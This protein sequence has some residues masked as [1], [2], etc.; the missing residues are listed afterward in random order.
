MKQ[1]KKLLWYSLALMGF[2]TV[3]GFGNVVNGFSFYGGTRAVGAWVLIFAL[4]FVP[5]ALMVGELGSAFKELGGGV[6]SWIEETVGP[7]LAYYAGWTYWVVHM[8]YISQKPQSTIIA[9]SWALFQDNRV[10]LMNPLVLQLLC[11]AV[12]IFAFYLSGKGLGILKKLSSVAGS[13]MFVMS[14]LFILMMM[15]APAITGASLAKIDWNFKNFVPT[16]DLTFFLNISILVFAV[17]GCEKISPYVNKMKDPSSQFPKGIIVMAVMV[18]VCAILGTVAMGMMFDSN[19]IPDDLLTNGAYYSFQRLGEYY[20]VG[21]LFVILYGLTNLISQ[22]AV[23]ILSI[24]AP[25]RMLLGNADRRFIPDSLLKQNKNGAY[26]NGLKMVFIIVGILIIIPAF[27][28]GSVNAMVKWLTKLNSVCMPM[29]YLWVF[30]AY[31]ALKKAGEKFP[32]EYRFTKKKGLGMGLGVWCFALTA[33]ACILG[34]YSE[35][36]FQLALNIITP[37]VLLGLGC[38]LPAI[39]KRNGT[40]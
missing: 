7:R 16:F 20:H 17:G 33:F 35:D 28:I 39:A 34:V 12:F 19:N 31:I 10:S 4:Y 14:L 21:N 23:M 22:F 9:G 36:A 6:S 18:A 38:I 26:T 25:L 24:D 2:M 37:C 1:E 11:L 40:K 27:G 3:W 32:A 29:R 30:V 8:P 15:A 5:Y 13:C